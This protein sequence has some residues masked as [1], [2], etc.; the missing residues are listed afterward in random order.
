M[1]RLLSLGIVHGRRMFSK[2]IIQKS[3]RGFSLTLFSS[4]CYLKSTPRNLWLEVLGDDERC[5]LHQSAI[6]ICVPAVTCKWFCFSYGKDRFEAQDK[7][8]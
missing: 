8:S 7:A 3:V 1:I 2:C 4:F 6:G 5:F